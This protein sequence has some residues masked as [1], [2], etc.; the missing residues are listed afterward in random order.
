MVNGTKIFYSSMLIIKLHYYICVYYIAKYLKSLFDIFYSTKS[1]SSD[2]FSN[3]SFKYCIYDSLQYFFV[4]GF[5]QAIKFTM[6]LNLLKISGV[7]IR[8][9]ILR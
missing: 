1:Y 3:T 4:I 6:I 7:I 5:L 2:E 9:I 8:T